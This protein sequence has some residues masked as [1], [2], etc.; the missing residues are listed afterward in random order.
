[1]DNS[2]KT[3]LAYR[4]SLGGGGLGLGLVG[5]GR[6]GDNDFTSTRSKSSNVRKTL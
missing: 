2:L 6:R 4:F 5:G 1:M 3:G